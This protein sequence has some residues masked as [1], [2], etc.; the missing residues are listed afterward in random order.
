MHATLPSWAATDFPGLRRGRVDTLQVNLGYKCNQSC[1]HCHV[2]SGPKRTGMM[3][4]DTVALVLEVLRVRA[5]P[6]LDVTGG[7][8][9]L[10]PH[11]RRL[12]SAARRLGL[13]SCRL[14][15]RTCATCWRTRAPARPSA[16]P[17]IA[18]AAPPGRAAAAAGR[19]PR[20][21]PHKHHLR[22]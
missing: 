2:D 21:E 16:S 6:T 5:I 14:C 11:F 15:G 9:E 13:R 10:S 20:R 17:T 1:L 4:G 19:W 12:V 3:D 18:A 7:A 22:P 8:P